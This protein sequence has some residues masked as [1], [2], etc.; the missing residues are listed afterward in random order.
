MNIVISSPGGI[1][2]PVGGGRI[3][4]YNLARQ[5]EERG[6]HIIVLEPS[7]RKKNYTFN[8]LQIR[9]YIGTIGN[10]F[11][12]FC[13]VNP[14]FVIS[15]IELLLTQQIDIIQVDAPWGTTIARAICALMRKNPLIVYNSQNL[16]KKLF[17]E[18]ATYSRSKRDAK[19]KDIVISTLSAYYVRVIEKLAVKLSDIILCASTQDQI[20][21][22]KE[23]EI[24]VSK[25]S[26]VA[27]GT[28]LKQILQASR[29][30][31]KFGLDPSK[32]TILFHGSYKYPPNLEAVDLIDNVIAPSI[33]KDG[34]PAEFVVAGSGI[35]TSRQSDFISFKG[36]V[37]DIAGLLKS[38]DI[39]L[40][41]IVRGGGTKLKALDYFAA[42]LPVVATTKGLEG[43]E[44]IDGEHAIIIDQV[45]EEFVNAVRCLIVS[46]TER[47][48][49]GN[50]A[51]KLAREKYDWDAIGSAL[52]GFYHRQ[53][54]ARRVKE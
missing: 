53:L 27:N 47:V 7:H 39:A 22:A 30:K 2:E 5:L 46:R 40:V 19:A 15:L 44:A 32:L 25:I 24:P 35:P 14:F 6:N 41:P 21:F 54:E 8:K 51:L 42:G 13:D 31:S 34:F 45:D 48:R 33:I 16:D 38:S 10:H 3:R 23:Y 9:N 11:S 49:L 37:E 17:A 28:N 29:N 1:T 52:D 43:I 12:L 4:C 20:S 50:N 36:Y 26:V 18:L